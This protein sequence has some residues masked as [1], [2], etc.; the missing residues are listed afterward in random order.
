[1]CEDD[2]KQKFLLLL[3]FEEVAE[4]V[5]KKDIRQKLRKLSTDF[6]H[7]DRFL[8]QP[9]PFERLLESEQNANSIERLDAEHWKITDLGVEDREFSFR[10]CV[11]NLLQNSIS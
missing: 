7:T 8:N 3:V 9:Q 2:T 10:P 6:F 5:N 1:M 11:V 4:P